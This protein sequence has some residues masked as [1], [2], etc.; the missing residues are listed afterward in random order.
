MQLRGYNSEI[1]KEE[2]FIQVYK[3]VL[4]GEIKNPE[5]INQVF[6]YFSENPDQLFQLHHQEEKSSRNP[7]LNKTCYSCRIK[8][9]LKRHCNVQGLV[10]EEEIEFVFQK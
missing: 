3:E 7:Y 10:E 4:Q 8:G 1:I 6:K 2:I 5:I 9:H